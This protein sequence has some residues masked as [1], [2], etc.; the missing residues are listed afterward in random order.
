MA[1]HASWQIVALIQ[2]DVGGVVTHTYIHRAVATVDHKSAYRRHSSWQPVKG[3][4]ARI[5]NTKL[6]YERE[7]ASNNGWGVQLYRAGGCDSQHQTETTPKYNN[8]WDR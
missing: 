5:H 4:T 6:E 7:G 8:K 3:R 1:G 2:S